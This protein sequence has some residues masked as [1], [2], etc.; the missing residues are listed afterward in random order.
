MLALTIYFWTITI[1]SLIITWATCCCLYPFVSKKQISRVYERMMA[2]FVLNAM[3]LP[4]FWQIQ[5]LDNRTDTERYNKKGE[6]KRFV[7]VA[8]HRSFVDSLITSRIQFFKTYLIGHVFTRIPV[9]GW[10]T[11][12]AGYISADRHD[13]VLNSTAVERAIER[14]ET[15]QCSLLIYPTGRRC[16]FEEQLDNFKT[17]AFRIARN[18]ELPILPVTLLGTEKAMPGYNIDYA[19]ITIVIDDPFTVNDDNYSKWIN[20]TRELMAINLGVTLED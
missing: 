15:E 8:N 10:L 18:T 5:I 12:M 6:E 13:P 9:F 7:I 20:Y 3:T 17:G 14:I 19:R 4:G 16:T 1:P 2:F 11:R